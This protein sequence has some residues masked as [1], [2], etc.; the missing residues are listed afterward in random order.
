MQHTIIYHISCSGP[1]SVTISVNDE[2]QYHQDHAIDAGTDYV[3]EFD[4]NYKDGEQIQNLTVYFQKHPDHNIEPEQKN[5]LLRMIRVKKNKINPLVGGYLP[6][7]SAWLDQQ[8]QDYILSKTMNHGGNMGWF[9]SMYYHYS[10]ANSRAEARLKSNNNAT[11]LLTSAN[12]AII[13]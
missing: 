9:G 2:P 7:S 11:S 12:T 10:V 5:L 8:S 13:K 1:V 4:C 3:A 6:F